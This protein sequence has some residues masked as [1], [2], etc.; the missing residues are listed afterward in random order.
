MA[1]INQRITLLER[2]IAKALR[3]RPVPYLRLPAAGDPRRAAVQ[4]EIATRKKAGQNCIVYEI[5]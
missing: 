2:T 3:S 4:D 5:V 1:T